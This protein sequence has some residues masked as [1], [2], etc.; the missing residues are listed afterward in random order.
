MSST[1]AGTTRKIKTPLISTAVLVAAGVVLLMLVLEPTDRR[2]APA[3]DVA[4]AG[5]GTADG[6]LR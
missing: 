6:T 2:A 5:N 4:T 1:K 3:A